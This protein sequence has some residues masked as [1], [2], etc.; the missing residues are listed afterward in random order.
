M[1]P[2]AGNPGSGALESAPVGYEPWAD[3]RRL[4]ATLASR[5]QRLGSRDPEG[6]A[7]ETF[8]RSW[9]N[10]TSR[11]ALDY[12]FR[13]SLKADAAVPDWSLE[14]LLAWLHTVLCYVVSEECNRVAY[15]REIPIEQDPGASEERKDA[16]PQDTGA[17]QLQQ[18]LQKELESILREC[19]PKLEPQY[20]TVLRMR[21]L[22]LKYDEIAARL[23][24]KENT[25][26][27]WLSRAVRDLARCVNRRTRRGRSGK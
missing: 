6:A 7:Q 24:E 18:L 23:R 20:R 27:T 9:Q 17:N 11:P 13:Q 10:A 16:E 4:L 1:Q 22:G 26:A 12:Y 15:R 2:Q 25:I 14:Q 8:A 21:G 19:F 5:A 3:Y